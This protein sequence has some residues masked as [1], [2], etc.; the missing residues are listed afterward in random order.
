ME[1][2]QKTLEAVQ[3]SSPDLEGQSAR[4][5]QQ[6]VKINQQRAQIAVEYKDAVRVSLTL[7][8]LCVLATRKTTLSRA[9]GIMRFFLANYALFFGELCAKN[10]RIMRELGK[11]CNMAQYY[12]FKTLE[13]DLK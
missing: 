11:L 5:Q 3:K 7:C 9:S 13:Q 4:I 12:P 10:P 8:L 1:T 6:I 2:K